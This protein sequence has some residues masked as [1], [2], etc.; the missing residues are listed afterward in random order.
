MKE[1][2]SKK[3]SCMPKFIDW[4][5]GGHKKGAVERKA[6]RFRAEFIVMT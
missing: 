4:E 2:G 1:E 3:G 6:R 5:K